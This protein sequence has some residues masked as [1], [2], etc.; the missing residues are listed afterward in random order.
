MNQHALRTFIAADPDAIFQL[1]ITPDR[2]PEWNSAITGVVDA[3]EHLTIGS[4]W[5][6]TVHALGQ[7]WPSRSTV[8]E[9][10]P[11]ARVFAYRSQSDDGNPSHAEW[12]WKVSAAPGGSDVAVSYALHPATF[13]RRV[14][15]AKIRNRQLRRTELPGTFTSLRSVLSTASSP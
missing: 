10:D 9:L 8:V 12:S 11:D 3:P 5:V 7:S 13:W 6:V 2:L 15:L 14:L 4:R 1:I